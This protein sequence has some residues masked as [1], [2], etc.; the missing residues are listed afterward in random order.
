MPKTVE[1]ARVAYL[2]VFRKERHE[3]MKLALRIRE[4]FGKKVFSTHTINPL[5]KRGLLSRRESNPVRSAEPAMSKKREPQEPIKGYQIVQKLGMGGMSTVFKAIHMAS[6]QTV[7]LKILYPHLAKNRKAL[8]RFVREAKLLIRFNH[9]NIIKG[10]QVGAS[11]G[12]VY[13][14]M[15]YVEGDSII[16]LIEKGHAFSEDDALS[17]ILQVAKALEYMEKMGVLHRDIKPGNILLT[18]ANRVKLF[19][20]GLAKTLNDSSSKHKD[21]TTVGTVHYISP[22]QARGIQDLDIRSDIYSLGVT[23]YH[24][25]IGKVPFEGTD[26]REVMVKQILESLASP[27]V[28]TRNISPHMHYFLEKMMAKDRKIRYQNPRELIEDIEAQ[29]RGR[30]TLSFTP[31]ERRNPFQAVQPSQ[32]KDKKLTSPPA[33]GWAKRDI[34]PTSREPKNRNKGRTKPE[35]KSF[36]KKNL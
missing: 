8:Q 9:E 35:L 18:Q 2:V 15:E 6:G 10:F 33:L 32:K 17:V 31:E 16:D 14:S 1:T 28:K 26:N 3:E 5:E 20:L 29:V 4:K 11:R 22:E 19:D 34:R 36:W 13:F 24:M 27:E 30:E 21:G 23:L 12:L 25:V 7:A